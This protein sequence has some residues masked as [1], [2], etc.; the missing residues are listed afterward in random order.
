M[1]CYNC[2]IEIPDDIEYCSGCGYPQQFSQELID[3][4]INKDSA[5]EDQL[6]YMTYNNVFF[7]IKALVKDEDTIHDLTQDTYI[8]AYRNLSQLKEPAAFRGWIKRIGHNLTIDY[9]RKTKPR[10]FSD[11]VSSESDEMLE[12]PDERTDSMPEAVMDQ[13]ET[14]RLID[15]ILNS[16]SDEQRVAVS[17]FYYQQKSIKEIAKELGIS[18]N[19]IKSRL[20]HG[21]NKVE[22]EVKELEKRG[23]KLY[24]LAPIPFLLLL[25]RTVDAQAAELP[26]AELLQKVK[27][28]YNSGKAG[29]EEI[30]S[31]TVST[32]G[33]AY[34]DQPVDSSGTGT[35]ITKAAIKELSKKGMTIKIFFGVI[36]VL[37]VGV[38]LFGVT[39]NRNN[40]GQ[41]NVTEPAQPAGEVGTPG[42]SDSAVTEDAE[43]ERI[44]TFEGIY[45][46]E[47]EER[48]YLKVEAQF[49]N[50][51][52][53][54]LLNELNNPLDIE[55]FIQPDGTLKAEIPS[56]YDENL[57]LTIKKD[58]DS[59]LITGNDAYY[60]SIFY[61]TAMQHYIGGSRSV[62]FFYNSRFD[63]RFKKIDQDELIYTE[64]DISEFL[65]TYTKDNDT[66]TLSLSGDEL[67][68]YYTNGQTEQ[69][70]ICSEYS[71]ENGIL[72][73]ERVVYIENEL[74]GYNQTIGERFIRNTRN[75]TIAVESDESIAPDTFPKGIY[76]VSE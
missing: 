30:Q 5:A 11:I 1:K 66:I 76:N 60:N 38:A 52:R 74:D 57:E 44:K 12:F 51:C 3:R 32:E 68:Y 47:E 18:E 46:C 27:E 9:L 71:I 43:L 23:T 26:D 20:F 34:S 17:M 8:K 56:G 59:L 41:Q 31:E 14:K 7:T 65:G 45:L 25:F 37:I 2:K 29:T 22:F 35:N 49:E 69:S 39:H 15:E 13:K 61:E 36:T 55:G 62:G 24:G 72:R 21:R 58:G 16:L 19:T 70:G 6:Y 63:G 67:N 42:T 40:N 75:N 48:L 28:Q 64:P 50:I 53:V 10:V 73:I 54:T 4:A 33:N